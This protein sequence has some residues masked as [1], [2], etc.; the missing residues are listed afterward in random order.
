MKTLPGPGRDVVNSGA[1]LAVAL[2][3]L[4]PF[5][6]AGGTPSVNCWPTRPL[7]LD[8]EKICFPRVHPNV[9][10]RCP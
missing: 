1:R 10:R 9:E 6:M 4:L 3:A 2:P 5:R 7:R 8:P